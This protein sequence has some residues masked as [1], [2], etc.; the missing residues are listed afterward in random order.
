M[1]ATNMSGTIL[2]RDDASLPAGLAI[3]REVFLPGWK[4]VKNFDGYELGREI[5]EAKW[6]FFYLAGEIRVAVLGRDRSK[7]LRRAVKCVLAKHAEQKFN[8]LEITKVVSKQFLGVPFMNVTAHSRHIQQG[9]CL[10]PAKDVVL[11]MP[12]PADQEN[13]LGSSREQH[14]AEETMKQHTVLISSS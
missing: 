10:V 5:E 3:E 14:H 12:V 4:A 7:T 13:N 9:I 1:L 11:G 2:I 6:H 8:S